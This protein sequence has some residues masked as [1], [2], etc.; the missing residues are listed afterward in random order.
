MDFVGWFRFRGAEN[1]AAAGF[2]VPRGLPEREGA[3][4][5]CGK[6]KQG[7][8]IWKEQAKRRGQAPYSP[9]GSALFYTAD[10]HAQEDDHAENRTL[11]ECGDVDQGHA[12]F[13]ISDDDDSQEGSQQRALS[14]LNAHAAQ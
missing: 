1:Q 6:E 4:D 3:S 5:E 12:A 8:P 13:E 7:M 11:I 10:D 2:P 9:L 14:A